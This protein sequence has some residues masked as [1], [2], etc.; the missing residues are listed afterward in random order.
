MLSLSDKIWQQD[1]QLSLTCPIPYLNPSKLDSLEADDSGE[2]VQ[3]PL[4]DTDARD[5]KSQVIESENKTASLIDA[6]L[7]G[8]PFRLMLFVARYV[9]SADLV[10][11]T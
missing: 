9:T 7:V 6:P 5:L 4:D 11:Y 8:A 3:I 2:I 10:N 1:I